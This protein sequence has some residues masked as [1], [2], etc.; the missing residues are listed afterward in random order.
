MNFQ[1]TSVETTEAT[2]LLS[3]QGEQGVSALQFIKNLMYTTF[4]VEHAFDG[5]DIVFHFFRTKENPTD[6]YWKTDFPNVLSD[7]AQDVFQA[8]YPRLKAAWTEEQD[9]WW[10]RANGFASV[11]MP[12]ERIHHFYEK[13]DQA[14]EALKVSQLPA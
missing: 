6:K 5:E 2:S 12:E 8:S 10:M 13:L 3:T 1:P 9:S 11:G 14:L 7:V 4:L